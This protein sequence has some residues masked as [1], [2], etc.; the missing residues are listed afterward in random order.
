MIFTWGRPVYK[1]G[2]WPGD[3]FVLAGR[4]HVTTVQCQWFLWMGDIPLGPGLCRAL[5]EWKKRSEIRLW[6]D[7]LKTDNAWQHL[8]A[9]AF[10]YNVPVCLHRSWSE[11]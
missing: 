10:S 3:R 1:S 7:P 4:L 5:G 9:R 6:L 8:N 11:Q 2:T